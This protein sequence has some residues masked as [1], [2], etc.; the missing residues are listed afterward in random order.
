[1]KVTFCNEENSD[2]YKGLAKVDGAFEGSEVS[3]MEKINDDRSLDEFKGPPTLEV[4]NIRLLKPVQKVVM[5]A[6]KTI[7]VVQQR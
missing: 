2:S 6:V 5:Q 4:Q 3:I 1:M 7:M